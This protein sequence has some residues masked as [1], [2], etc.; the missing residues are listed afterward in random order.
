M[1]KDV[2]LTPEGLEKLKDELEDLSDDKRREVA[3]RIKEAREFGD[4]IGELRVRRRQERA[5]DARGADRSSSRTSS[6]P[7]RSIDAKDLDT[8]VVRV[9]SVGAR[10][11]R[12]D[13]QVGQVHDRRLG[14]GQA[15]GE[16]SSPTSRPSAARCSA[17]SAGEMV[18][19]P[20]PAR[21][22][23]ASSRSRRSTSQRVECRR[24]PTSSS[25]ARRR[26]SSSACAR[27]ASS[28]SRTPTRASSRSRHVRSPTRAWRPARRPTHATASPAAWPRAAARARW[29]SSTWS[30]APAGSSCRRASTCSATSPTSACSRS[31]SATSSASTA[32]VPLAAAAS[33]RCGSTRWELLAK[34]L[35][36][37]PDKYHGLHDVETR[38][39]QRELDLIANEEARELFIA[40][41]RVIAAVR[42]FLD[43]RGFVEVET[44]VLQPLY[45]GALARPFATHHN[46]LDRDALPA[47]RH[48]AVPQAADRRRPRAGLRDRQGLPQRGP[49]AQAQPRV[50][51]ARALP[52]LRRLR[53]TSSRR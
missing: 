35:R 14:R 24:G 31:T 7:R 48:R 29:R 33:C 25:S 26:R 40:A 12:E 18:E 43:E 34:S 16:A 52:G 27:R 2:I 39:R 44:P 3:E 36:P 51:D 19:V 21:P 53:A 41:R 4:I 6:A 8:D 28:R 49:V 9:G 5:G 13:R 38:Y 20:V 22:A 11:G 50:H 42:R 17:T 1:P 37:P 46:A 32:R 10:Q 45:G 15:R 23:S 47:H 30:T